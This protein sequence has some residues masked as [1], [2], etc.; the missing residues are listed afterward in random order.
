MSG[1]AAVYLRVSTDEQETSNQRPDC[2]RL[3]AARGWE[4]L[5]IE[6][7]ESGAAEVRTQWNA[8]MMRAHRG[9]FAAVVVWAIDRIGRNRVR[10]AHDLGELLR[11]RVQVVSVREPWLD[12]APGPMRDLLVQVMAWVAEGE[13]ARL[14][15][16]TKAGMARARAAG[17]TIG[18][19]PTS[20]A[21][22]KRVLAMRRQLQLD[23]R[24][25]PSIGAIARD[26]KVPK[27]TVRRILGQKGLGQGQG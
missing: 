3:C 10:V 11:W 19:P 23:D 24:A 16:R 26:L 17:K 18:R 22:V 2:E 12:T 14:I 15:E 1:R 7:V 13:R 20:A 25:E 4:P 5:I 8:I 9:D 6:D 21:T 27:T